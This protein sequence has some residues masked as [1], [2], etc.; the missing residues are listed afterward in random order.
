MSKKIYGLVS[1]LG[2]LTG[3]FTNFVAAFK[4]RGGTDEELHQILVGSG[5]EEFTSQVVNLAVKI[6]E[7]ISDSFHVV[8][9]YSKTL[10]EMISAGNYDWV[11]SEINQDRLLV[12]D[13]VEAINIELIHYD[14]HMK[15]DDII[16]DLDTRGLRPATLPELLAFGATYMKEQRKFSIVALGSVWLGRHSLRY[17]LYLGSND[18]G[19]KLNLSL[20]DIGWDSDYLFAA[21]RK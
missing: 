8:V 11:N 4:K 3:F 19:R 10:T 17:A 9:D 7:R 16:L 2:V 21:V 20:W 5:S 18:F 6:A 14:K 15:A 1:S 12:Q 13:S